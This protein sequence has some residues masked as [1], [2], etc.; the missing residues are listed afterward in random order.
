[1]AAAIAADVQSPD[2][3]GG[4]RSIATA[5]ESE[6]IV[7]QNADGTIT[8]RKIRSKDF[9]KSSNVAAGVAIP[10]QVVVPIVP[11]RSDH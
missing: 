2:I 6:P 9:K 11:N 7:V 5:K 10:A 8:V 4:R 3:Q 1:M